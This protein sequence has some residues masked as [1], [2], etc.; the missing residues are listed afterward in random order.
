MSARGIARLF[1]LV[2][3]AAVFGATD[4]VAGFSSG[5]ATAT[6]K[7]PDGY[8][9]VR[10]KNAGFSMAVPDGWLAIDPASKSFR[11][12][13]QQIAEADPELASFV[14]Q[15]DPSEVKLFALDQTNPNFTSNALVVSSGYDKS[16]ISQP[17]AVKAGVEA[18]A[19]NLEGIEVRKTK[20]DGR[21]SLE[22]VA[23]QETSLRD[24]TSSRVYSTSYF[25]PAK[26][27]VLQIVFTTLQDGREDP[28][29]RTMIDSVNLLR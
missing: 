24:G 21:R 12:L 5:G 29:V 28:T 16:V 26:K 9:T 2:V 13:K 7:P 6:A 23:T 11:D 25:V 1:C 4:L 15:I 27:D 8:H 14:E 17:K 19:G 22:L 18:Q 3:L 10:V 20:V